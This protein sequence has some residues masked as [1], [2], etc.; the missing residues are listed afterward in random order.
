[1]KNIFYSLL[2]LSL[3]ACKQKEVDTPRSNKTIKKETSLKN[4]FLDSSITSLVKSK[5]TIKKGKNIETIISEL[6]TTD[7]ILHLDLSHKKIDNLPDLSSY[8]ILS[9]DISF[10]NLDTIMLS[11]LPST[12]TKLNASNNNLSSFSSLNY[13]C[14][15]NV[16]FKTHT[17]SN[18][19]L[20]EINLSNN[21]LKIFKIQTFEN[22]KIGVKNQLRK[23]NLSNNKLEQLQFTGYIEYLDVSNNINLPSE[24][25]YIIDRIDTLLQKNNKNKLH[26]NSI[27]GNNAE[28]C[29]KGNKKA[30]SDFQN[31][32]YILQT[33]GQ[34]VNKEFDPFFIKYTKEKYNISITSAPCVIFTES[35]CYTKT[36]RARVLAKFGNDIEVKM[37]DEAIAAF[38]KTNEYI[39]TIKPKID[40]GFVFRGAHTNAE[41]TENYSSIKDFFFKNISNT[42]ISY[43]TIYFSIII[44][45]DGTVSNLEFSKEPKP[46]IKKEVERLVNLMPKWIPATYYKENVR[47][48]KKLSLSSKK[49]MEMMAEIRRKRKLKNNLK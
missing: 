6:S 2:F 37:K 45:K 36:M 17:N 7:T 4:N 49:E 3:I 48:E 34:A 20:K 25:H 10:N 14:N 15:T 40:T 11:K 12:L 13:K 42:E 30:I 31:N 29:D 5:E 19:N 18:L 41:F 28:N 9:L 44:E 16:S 33:L 22:R 26:S 23:I 46:E 39:S 47:I 43:W 38:K 21:N 27:F 8:K 35:N 32:I 1:M 24:N